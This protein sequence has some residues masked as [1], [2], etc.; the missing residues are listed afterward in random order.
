MTYEEKKHWLMRYRELAEDIEDLKMEYRHMQ[1]MAKAQAE[2]LSGEEWAEENL[3]KSK[4][5]LLEKEREISHYRQQLAKTGD[6]I[7]A[8]IDQLPDAQQRTV[9]RGTYLVEGGTQESAGESLHYDK[10]WAYRKHK[11]AMAALEIPEKKSR[12]V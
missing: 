3:K 11:A 6:E 5:R 2:E 8:V 10:R 4:E 7:E 1:S 12:E 9:L